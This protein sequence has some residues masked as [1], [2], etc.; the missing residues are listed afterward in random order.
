MNEE[1]VTLNIRLMSFVTLSLLADII[2]GTSDVLFIWRLYAEP[3]SLV[4]SVTD[5]FLCSGPTAID[6]RR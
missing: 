2:S 1:H 5:V 6:A 3:W 4:A